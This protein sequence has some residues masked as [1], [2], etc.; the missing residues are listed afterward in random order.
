MWSTLDF[1]RKHQVFKQKA[2]ILKNFTNSAK[3]FLVREQIRLALKLESTIENAGKILNENF[4]SLKSNDEDLSSSELKLFRVSSD[5]LP[6]K[7]NKSTIFKINYN[8]SIY[9]INPKFYYKDPSGSDNLFVFGAI[10]C[11][12][13]HQNECLESLKFLGTKYIYFEYMDYKCNYVFISSN[14]FYLIKG[15]L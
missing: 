4:R 1:E 10:F 5:Q 3:S 2:N 7:I 9:W 6:H 15:I 11:L 12:E 8:E 14:K 13:S